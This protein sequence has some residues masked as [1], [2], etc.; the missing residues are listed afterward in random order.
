MRHLNSR[1][2]LVSK[3]SRP[4]YLIQALISLLKTTFNI[5]IGRSRTLHS[6]EIP[7][8]SLTQA[9]PPGSKNFSGTIH[10]LRPA[11]RESSSTLQ[12]Q[13]SLQSQEGLLDE[14]E[15]TLFNF[16]WNG[17]SGSHT[18]HMIKWEQIC[19][20]KDESGLGIKRFGDWNKACMM[21]QL[22]EVIQGQKSLW[23]D[24][25][26]G[27]YLS[28]GNIWN[29]QSRPYHSM[30]WNG[31]LKARAWVKEHLLQ[32]WPHRGIGANRAA[33]EKILE[34]SSQNA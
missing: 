23:M 9:P 14:T 31:I 11:S 2:C 34:N 18:P 29:V 7:R 15:R 27:K 6:S 28:K 5:V 12:W 32:G 16:L 19:K 21:E 17:Q 22:W 8:P 3:D 33:K 24:W 20:P 25:I 1:P 10:A 30:A 26:K 4:R 13:K